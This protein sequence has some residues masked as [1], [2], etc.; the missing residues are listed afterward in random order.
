MSY[1]YERVELPTSRPTYRYNM[2]QLLRDRIIE[3]N[4]NMAGQI[5][6]DEWRISVST[7]DN[8]AA[9]G[10]TVEHGTISLSLI[11]NAKT[12]AKYKNVSAIP[13]YNF[14]YTAPKLT[15]VLASFGYAD[16]YHYDQAEEVRNHL[17]ETFV[18]KQAGAN[19]SRPYSQ[20]TAYGYLK[21]FEIIKVND[22]EKRLIITREGRSGYSSHDQNGD[23]M[24]DYPGILLALTDSTQVIRFLKDPNDDKRANAPTLNVENNNLTFTNNEMMSASAQGSE[25]PVIPIM[26]DA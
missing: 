4:P 13:V 12:N 19:Y 23:T 22:N 9:R 17:L 3:A 25:D 11:S 6:W 14:T 5:D 10:E 7:Y 21:N 8:K 18:D 24:G 26:E 2:F 20:D 1:N 15:E 16:T